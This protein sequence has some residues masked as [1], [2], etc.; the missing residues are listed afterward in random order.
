[1]E[2][3]GRTLDYGITLEL[4]SKGSTHYTGQG[5]GYTSGFTCYQAEGIGL[6]LRV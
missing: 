5:T 1:M 2:M 6:G 3:F 4:Q